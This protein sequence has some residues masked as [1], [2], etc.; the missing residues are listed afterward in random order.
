MLILQKLPGI[1]DFA[2]CKR[3]KL[4]VFNILQDIYLTREV[5]S[6]SQRY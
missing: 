5:L 3:W 6:Y 4:L 1:F 2:V